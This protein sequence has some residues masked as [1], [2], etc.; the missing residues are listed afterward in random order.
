MRD[1]LRLSWACAPRTR[2]PRRSPGTRAELDIDI[3]ELGQHGQTGTGA[4]H[5]N[6]ITELSKVHIY[7]KQ[8]MAKPGPSPNQGKVPL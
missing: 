1:G 8:A 7:R 5:S 3:R 4:L 2:R 6:I